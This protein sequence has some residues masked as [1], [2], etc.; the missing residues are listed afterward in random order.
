MPKSFVTWT[1]DGLTN[2]ITQGDLSNFHQE[3]KEFVPDIIAFQRVKWRAHPEDH[4]RILPNSGDAENYELLSTALAPHY[5]IY[6]NLSDQPYGGQM[7]LVHKDCKQPTSVSYSLEMNQSP[8]RHG[9]ITKLHYPHLVIWSVW[10]PT[11]GKGD[12]KRLERRTKW[13]DALWQALAQQTSTPQIVLG[14]FQAVLEDHHMT[15]STQYWHSQQRNPNTLGL[16]DNVD[17]GNR[18]HPATTANER[19]ALHEGLLKAN[20]VDPQANRKPTNTQYTWHNPTGKHALV[21]T[22]AFVSSSIQ[23]SGGVEANT[24]IEPVNTKDPFLGSSHRPK[25]LSLKVD[26]R[27]R[28]NLW[29]N[30]KGEVEART[31][32]EEERKQWEEEEQAVNIAI[33]NNM[34]KNIDQR[35]APKQ[36]HHR[37]S[38]ETRDEL[39]YIKTP[40]L[41]EELDE[42]EHSNRPYFQRSCGI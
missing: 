23:Q 26:W 11:I 34:F 30:R 16:E 9:R 33:V 36:Y 14:N 19:M 4:T 2:R 39:E 40:T 5:Q 15:D 41:E 32:G 28:I 42:E 1:C 35:L 25:W 37:E 27:E 12:S 24:T 38:G 29:K 6:L 31:G 17:I 13:D 7:L 21:T 10:A 8:A 3:I 20:L 22:Y 18:G